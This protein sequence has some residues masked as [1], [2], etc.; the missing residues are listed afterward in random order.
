MKEFMLLFRQPSY[1]YSEASPQKMQELSRKWKEW[2][3]SIENQGKLVSH[4]I[5]L[6][7]EGKVVKANGIITDG[8]FVEIK[9]KLGSYIIVNAEG[10]EDATNLAKGCPAIEEGGSVEVRPIITMY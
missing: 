6:D 10:F 8:P 4:G 3:S 2:S 5:R 9:E 7:A 1:D